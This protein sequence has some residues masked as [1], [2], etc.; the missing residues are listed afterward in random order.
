VPLPLF[1]DAPESL[2]A[3]QQAFYVAKDGRYQLDI[4]DLDTYV[5]TCGAGVHRALKAE[6]ETNKELKALGRTPAEIKTILADV[7]SAAANSDVFKT[8]LAQHE[9]NWGVERTAFQNEIAL[10]RA[11]EH[12][13][14]HE[15]VL[16]IGLT[17]ARATAEGLRFLPKL[18]ADRFRVDAEGGKRSITILDEAGAPMQIEEAG[19]K[20]AATF[21]DLFAETIREYPGSFEGSGGGSGANQKTQKAASSKVLSRSEFESLSPVERSEKMRS[22]WTLQD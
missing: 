7:E 17:K 16:V 14:I 21:G 1:V 8:M 13:V 9:S 19:F 11:H 15:A 10:T 12:A 4:S 5:E 22:G 20:R 18:L 2:P 6:R 3:E